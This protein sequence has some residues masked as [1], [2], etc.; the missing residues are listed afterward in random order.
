M[1]MRKLILIV[2]AVFVFV[3][4]A[5]AQNRTVTGKVTSPNGKQGTQTDKDGMYS[6]SVPTTVKNLT[7]TYVNF[8]SQSKSIGNNTVIN[9]GLRSTDS[10]LEEVVVV[11]YGTA[12]RKE[13]TGSLSSVKGAA[14]AEKPIQSFEQALAGRASGVQITMPSGV[15][16]T[17][18]VFRIRGINSL[19]LSSSPLIVVDGTPVTTGDVAGSNAA[20][21]ALASINPADIES[22]DIAKDAAATAIY[23]SRAAN[24]VV[25]ITTK[26]GRAGKTRVNYSASMGFT[27]AYG[28]P[29][30]LNAQQYTDYKNYVASTSLGVNTTNPAGSGYIKYNLTTGPDGN[31]INTNWANVIYRQG[32]NQSH[33]LNLSGGSDN[34]TYYF[35]GGYT[36]QE[37]ILV[38]NDFTRK[39]ILMNVDARVNKMISLGGKISYSN[40]RNRVSSATGSLGDA[41][42]TGG[43]GR[44]ALTNSPNIS[45]YNNDGSYNLSGAGNFIGQQGNALGTG[46]VGFYN[47]SYLFD[48]NRSNSETN[49]IQSNVNVQIKP[50]SWLT[51]KSL[52]A[53][54]YILVD[55]DIFRDAK[56]GDGV[57]NSGDAFA[58]FSK[59]KRWTW[60]NTLQIDKTFK[61]K[62]TFS[63]LGGLEQDRRTTNQF[64]LTR[65]V[66]TDPVYTVIQGGFTTDVNS[67]LGLGENYLQSAFGRFNYDY[68]KKYFI[69]A[70]VRSDKYSAL[71]NPKETF[72]GF[73]AAWEVSQEKFWGSA[74]RK[75]FSSL[76]LKGSYG[77]V[78]NVAGILDYDTYSTFSSG[79]FGGNGSL[80]FTNA[81]NSD[82]KW[83]TSKQLNLGAVIGF[84]K[85]RMS[86]EMTYYKNN[87]SNLILRVPQSPSTGVPNSVLQNVGKMYNKGIELTLSGNIVNTKNFTWTTNFNYTNNQNE[88]TELAPGLTEILTGTGGLETVN[89]T[90]V[91]YPAGYINVVRSGG[92]DP[93]TGRR[94]LYNKV[95]NTI[96]YR[97]GTLPAGEFAYQNTD[98]TRYNLAS[99][100][101]TT[102]NA[103]ADAVMYANSTPK[104]I[105]GFSN[106]FRYKGFD[107]DVLFTYQANFSIYY[108]THAGLFDQRFWN[109]SVEVLDGW[110]KFGDITDIP[111]PVYGDNVSNGSGLPISFNV[112]KGDFIKLKNLT[113]G[114][115][116]S[117]DAL[118][119]VKINNVRFYVSGQNLYIFTKYPGPDPEVSSNGNGAPTGQGVDRNTLANGR[120]MTVGL[121]VGF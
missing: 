51:Y 103:A 79:V 23:G 109:N 104:V 50:F 43:F 45:P 120:T 84:F 100:A 113:L 48:K 80:G 58:T 111:K 121:N 76:K 93:A 101:A 21:N 59:F 112:F 115:N 41:F 96:L 97:F 31:P 82:L 78:G 39:N 119:K 19:S 64:G 63:V 33:N 74:I 89:R 83:E 54:D 72:Y 86:L 110:R 65:R 60:S 53:I 6:I 117:A 105:G 9:I 69:T 28:I 55:N 56:H 81:G 73:S 15:L 32:F 88:V 14:I 75:A 70:N 47:P 34:T 29:K 98:G 46:Q 106:N 27:T 13:V 91:G 52:Y 107:L 12:K 5:A 57:T 71:P 66:V 61:D 36:S 30:V 35:S 8:A 3:L 118:K 102:V 7:F 114:Y 2:M 95:G 25:F 62:H 108:G 18:P 26:R 87:I 17:P 77:K 22:M 10:K 85:D 68:K 49:H 11:G 42:S 99:G 116:I 24:G 20:G 37:G 44:L 40:E 4:N 94:V 90:A 1:Q 16:N 38:G 92:A 67:G